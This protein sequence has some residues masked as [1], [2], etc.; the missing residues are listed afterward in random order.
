MRSLASLALLLAL[1]SGVAGCGA[2]GAT[3]D[4]TLVT[5]E[6]RAR[7]LTVVDLLRGRFPAL[8]VDGNGASATVRIRRTGLAPVVIVDGFRTPFA[9]ALPDLL[10]ADVV[11]VEVFT[12]MADTLIYGADAAESGVV[13]I[14]TRL[15]DDDPDT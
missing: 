15:G 6:D 4:R 7:N 10:A 8:A 12:S 14:T 3:S 11:E 9:G 1:A 13:R 2:S 5:D